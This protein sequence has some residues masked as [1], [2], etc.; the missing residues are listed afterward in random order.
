[1]KPR[2]R[3]ELHTSPLE[4]PSVPAWFAE[5]TI[6]SRYLT[7]K[8]LLEALTQQIR[9]VRGHFSHY[10]PIDFLALLD[11]RRTDARRLL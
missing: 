5:V 1:M 7:A 4:R 2:Q 10:E 9:L 3:I 11:Q 6:L 8:G